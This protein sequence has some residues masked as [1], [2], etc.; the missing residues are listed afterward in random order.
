MSINDDLNE[1]YNL[2]TEIRRLKNTIKNL[3]KRKKICNDR[4]IEYLKIN[5]FPGIKNKYMELKLETKKPKQTTVKNISQI[6]KV[7]NH[8]NIDI[9]DNTIKD[10]VNLDNKTQENEGNVESKEQDVLIFKIVTDKR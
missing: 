3:K 10:I 2:E 6:K 1:F 9:N 8:I 4:I 7:L 5:N